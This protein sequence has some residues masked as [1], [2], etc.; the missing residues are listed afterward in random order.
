MSKFSRPTFNVDDDDLE[1]L[2]KEF[3]EK[4]TMPS[5]KVYRKTAPPPLNE[6]KKKRSLFAERLA[7]NASSSTATMPSLEDS[8]IPTLEDP[9]V[10]ST[11]SKHQTRLEEE[12]EFEP[13]MDPNPEPHVPVSKKMIDLTSLL[14]QVLGEIK[15]HDAGTVTAPSLPSAAAAENDNKRAR[16]QQNG[17]PKPVHR[18]EFK[19][20]LEAQRNKEA[21]AS[22]PR[23]DTPPQVTS[24]QVYDDDNDRRIGEMS[25][26]ELEDARQE[27]MNT[28]SPESIALLMKGLKHKNKEVPVK[29]PLTK[30][31]V[32]FDQQ[33]EDKD[34]LLQMKKQYFADVPMENDKLAWM[35]NRF[36]TPA[37][38]KQEAQRLLEL[39]HENPET[40]ATEAEK[41]YRKVRFD[42]QGRIID[43]TRE[44]PRH[45]GL[46]HHGDEPDKAGYTLAELFYLAR[47]QVP[48]QRSMVL[49]TLARIITL[50][51]KATK[52]LSASDHAVWN[53]VL[54][55][56]TGKEHAATIYLRSALDD[57][58]LIVLVSAI[59]ALSALVL[60]DDQVW[61]ASLLDATEF[62]TFLGHVARPILPEG[63][64]QIKRKGL[65]DK[66]TELV[67]RVRQSSG[68]PVSEQE[69][70]DDAALAERDLVRGLVKMDTLARIRY[71]LSSENS[72]LIQSD[73][74]SVDRL[75]RILVRMAE[76]G[77]DVCESIEEEE[78]L[79]PVITWGIINTQWPMT[80]EQEIAHYPSLAAVRLLTVLAQGSKQIAE[81]IV[82]KATITLRFLVTCPSAACDGMKQRAHALQLETLKLIRVLACYGLIVPTLEDLQAPVM[83]WLR[84]VLSSTTTIQES[85]RAAT[86]MGLLEVLLYAAA[87]PH[88]TVPAHAIVWHQPTAYLPAVMAVLR[89]SRDREE[90]EVYIS[91][92]GYL[93]AWASHISL[94]PPEAETVREVWKA[95]IQEDTWFQSGNSV[96]LGY[97][98]S[99]SHVLRYIQF[100]VAYAS[101]G[102]EYHDLM[103]D[104]QVRLRSAQVVHLLKDCYAK[105]IQGRYAFWI[106]INQCQDKDKCWG[107]SLNLAELECAI[108][109]KG[110]IETWLAQNFL[111]LCL[112]NKQLGDLEAFY[113]NHDEQ[114]KIISKA[115]FTYDG[116]P[117]KTL[118]YTEHGGEESIQSTLEASC[119]ILSPIDALYH[120]DKSKVAQKS[121]ADAASV[122]SG[123]IDLANKMFYTS[124]VHHEV[125]IITLMKVFLIGDREG[126]MADMESEREIFMDQ[127][128]SNRLNQWLDY[129]CRSKTN[130]DKLEHAWRKS[131]EYIRQAQVPF[132]QFYQGFVG[133]YAAVSFGH[134]GFARLLVYLVTQIDIVDY[135]HLLFSD[136]RD[137]LPTLEQVGLKEVPVLESNELEQLRSAG[138]KLLK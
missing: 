87:D 66:L 16:G 21:T 132:F 70:R 137:I 26:Q 110:V 58:N 56:F 15:E 29:A 104:V 50:A 11:E 99:T 131:S 48:S 100:I 128:V 116:R 34:D 89:A 3:F 96:A 37:I 82:E 13:V 51:R 93:G 76:A 64:S 25:Q 117:I 30:K 109:D 35:D 130:A 91:A 73:P 6:P 1:R 39:E 7:G 14:G 23:L 95:V 71:L 98:A 9:V 52:D 74:A 111:Q 119:F 88:K 22:T 10:E 8:S 41:V 103:D 2:Q 81:S 47:S 133:Q 120:L 46:H 125:A 136:Y 32:S 122:V 123:T 97:T 84:A 67:D 105:D 43:H 124:D 86:A 31:K 115:L 44:I 129:L 54:T 42:L 53:N 62:N 40:E 18:S 127:G 112:P 107:L 63:A 38:K 57:R 134:H 65:N 27:I 90:V 4:E 55:V 69:Q 85:T 126:R 20:R 138:L 121:K 83:E 28:L 60:D 108:K 12:P 77:Q 92:L 59:K 118:M 106:W 72:E 101:I 75:V 17:F 61:E 36:L 45:Q 102:Q 68:Q 135:R 114:A 79:E 94:F 49:T 19:K 5:A 80:N 113:F 33:V 78:L 24:E